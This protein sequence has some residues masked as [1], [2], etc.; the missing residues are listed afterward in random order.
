MR[1]I[2]LPASMDIEEYRNILYEH[3]IE[4]LKELG[5]KI[6]YIHGLRD[7]MYNWI[8]QDK[9]G[10]RV[11]H[12]NTLEPDTYGF[13]ETASITIIITG[14]RLEGFD[15]TVRYNKIRNSFLPYG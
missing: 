6:E 14:L 15:M 3:Y 1:S 11:V 2:K 5:I 12:L 7:N 9:D 8:R 13:H 4:V 10:S